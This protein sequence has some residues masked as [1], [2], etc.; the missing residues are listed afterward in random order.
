MSAAQQIL[1]ALGGWSN[2]SQLDACITRL[3]V[4]IKDP[5]LIDP[6]AIKAAGAHDVILVASTAQVVVGPDAD[7]LAS[8]IQEL[9]P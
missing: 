7:V 6:D 4:E 8:H 5:T 2:I 1:D 9:A 3:R